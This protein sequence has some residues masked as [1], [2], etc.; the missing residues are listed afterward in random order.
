MTV[1]TKPQDPFWFPSS[2]EMAFGKKTSCHISTKGK[3]DSMESASARTS[4]TSVD[5][6][7]EM[8]SGL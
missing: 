2:T 7:V 8:G 1:S 6:E 5:E 3:R 4:A